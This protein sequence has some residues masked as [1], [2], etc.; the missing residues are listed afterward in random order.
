MTRRIDPSRDSRRLSDH[1]I[2]AIIA[3][4]K[5]ENTD[6]EIARRLNIEH[7][8]VA[9]YRW[10]AG[11][12][13]NGISRRLLQIV[14]D[15]HARCT[16]C[17]QVKPLD[18][19]PVQ[20]R[21]GAIQFRLSY[22]VDCRRRQINKAQNKS[23][24]KN[25]S[26]RFTRLQARARHLGVVCTITREQFLA[27]WVSQQ[28]RCFYTDVPL[29]VSYGKGKNPRACSV[30]KIEPHLGYVQGNVVFAANRINTM[31]HDVTL[32]EMKEWMPKW[33]ARVEAFRNGIPCA[34]VAPGPF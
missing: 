16:R 13:P 22:C 11:L 14:D 12:P 15:H 27:Q 24:A 1:T 20:R 9:K 17:H 25:I 7:K 2:Q 23:V 8:T 34:Q 4:Q 29:L 6:R 5:L 33:Y 32:Q 28:M 31:K 10:Q 3:L 18:G 30:D 19:W 26:G 21:N